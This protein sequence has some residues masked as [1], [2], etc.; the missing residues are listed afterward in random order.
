[1]YVYEA[2]FPHRR[3]CRI[4]IGSVNSLGLL[5]MKNLN[6]VDDSAAIQINANGVESP[7]VLRG[8]SEPDLIAPYDG[9]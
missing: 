9:R 3:R 6:I 4:R 8:C 2:L 1:M 7:A 5:R